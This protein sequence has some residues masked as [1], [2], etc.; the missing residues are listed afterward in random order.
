MENNL[1]SKVILITGASSGIGEATALHLAER[2]AK[3][4][5][6]ARRSDLLAALAAR[7]TAAGGTAAYAP[8]DVTQRADLESL[9]QLALTQFG[10]VDVL[11]S[12]A[13]IAPI[14][15][16]D[17]GK[18]T[19]W[20]AMIDVNIKGL[21]YGIAAA[22]PVFRRQG[23][24]HFVTLLSTAGLTVSPTMAV[25]GG[26]KNAARAITEGLRQEAGPKLRVTAISPGFVQTN[27]ADSMGNP[28]IR[29]QIQKQMDE[30]ALPPA[31]VARAIAFAIEQ[32][33]EVDINEIII[34]PTA[35]A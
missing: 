28:E 32:P 15:P 25:Y 4:V 22:L 21:L 23:F 33:A 2:G 30:M 34:R 19:D 1:T 8:T 11:I 18:V 31:A 24:G 12:N 16:L 6:G 29:T 9:V 27:L 13:G 17:E 14:S 26:T 10:Q 35:Q 3:V 5:L 20:E 7:I